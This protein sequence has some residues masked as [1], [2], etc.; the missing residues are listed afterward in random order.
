MN[1]VACYVA[2]SG[3]RTTVPTPQRTMF[4]D[5]HVKKLGT[6]GEQTY[7]LVFETGDEVLA[8]ILAF[9]RRCHITAAHFSAIGGFSDAVLGYFDVA[10]KEYRRIPIDEQVEVVSLTGD[11]A[12]HG[13]EPIVHAHAVVGRSDGSARA[14]HLLEAHVR[15]TLEVVLTQSPRNLR[16]RMD[17]ATGLPLLDLDL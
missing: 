4:D 1:L 8:G 13:D 5:M 2:T 16:R 11:I 10:A 3:E 14:G 7:A 9:A 15:P 17:D 12:L 6:D